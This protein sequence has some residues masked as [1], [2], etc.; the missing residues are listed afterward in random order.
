[1]NKSLKINNNDTLNISGRAEEN[2]E[3]PPGQNSRCPGPDSNKVSPDKSLRIKNDD[4]FNQYI[5]MPRVQTAADRQMPK[6]LESISLYIKVLLKM[7]CTMD[8]LD[9]LC[10]QTRFPGSI[11]LVEGQVLYIL[12]F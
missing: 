3:N 10:T 2:S 6:K 5:I 9:C 7:P 12:Y 11:I 4:A 8:D 1:L